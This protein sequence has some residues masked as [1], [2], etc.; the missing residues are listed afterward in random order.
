V[1]LT[2][3]ERLI[4]EAIPECS[5]TGFPPTI[6]EIGE[7]IGLRSWRVLRLSLKSLEDKGF[8]LPK[9]KGRHR[10]IVLASP[11]KIAA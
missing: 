8:L 1:E 4:L 3:W 2:K 6:T 9:P 11:P 10:G 5:Q 7:A